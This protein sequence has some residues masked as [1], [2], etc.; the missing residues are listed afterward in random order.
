MQAGWGKC[1]Q[2][3]MSGFCDQS[4]GRCQSTAA[5][6]TP[7]ATAASCADIPP[8]NQYTCAQ[9]VINPTHKPLYIGYLG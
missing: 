2:A 7:A 5:P 6:S 9:Q 1:S 4:C 3:F 8:N